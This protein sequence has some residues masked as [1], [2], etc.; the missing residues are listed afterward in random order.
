MDQSDEHTNRKVHE[1]KE[2]RPREVKVPFENGQ[3]DVSLY[4]PSSIVHGG[5]QNRANIMGK[6][7]RGLALPSSFSG[8][9]GLEELAEK[10]KSFMG[11]T[12]GKTGDG[13]RNL[14]HCKICGK[15]GQSIHIQNHIEA[16]HLEGVS[17]PCKQCDK[18]AK[19]RREL[20]EHKHRRHVKK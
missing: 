18:T 5:G 2:V 10:V 17:L 4:R 19:S 7:E 1:K 6:N 15:E 11:T 12:L 14:Y 20:T 8:G 16:N 9:L 13:K 3:N